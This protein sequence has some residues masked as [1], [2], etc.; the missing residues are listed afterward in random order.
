[1]S[2]K[3]TVGRSKSTP[4]WPP[5]GSKWPPGGVPAPSGRPLG[6][7]S[8]F[9]ARLGGFGAASGPQLRPQDGPMLKHLGEVG[10]SG[11]INVLESTKG[12]LP[13]AT[14]SQLNPPEEPKRGPRWAQVGLKIAPKRGPN[15]KC[16]NAKNARPSYVFGG[17]WAP[18]WPGMAA[19][20][21]LDAVG[22]GHEVQEGRTRPVGAGLRPNLGPLGPEVGPQD[23]PKTGP[24][25]PGTPPGRSSCW[26][27]EKRRRL[28]RR[29]PF[30]T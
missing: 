4:K 29:G 28:Y 16:G 8:D 18:T 25:G 14:W 11:A 3:S 7:K 2:P 5:G 24:G 17:F 19:R 22:R 10:A 12:G 9:R 20:R 30:C 1:M 13:G 26:K 27:R 23:G 15:E 21:A 6:S